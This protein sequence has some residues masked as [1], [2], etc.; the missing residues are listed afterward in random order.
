MKAIVGMLF[1]AFMLSFGSAKGQNNSNSILDNKLS[2]KTNNKTVSQILDLISAEEKVFFSFDSEIIDPEKTT[3]LSVQNKTIKEILDIILGNRFSYK[4]LGDQIIIMTK[5]EIP[6]I[7]SKIFAEKPKIFLLKGR[8]I[9]LYD[10]DVISYASILLKGNSIGT[11][12]NPDGEFE[13]KI[14]SSAYNDTI[15]VSCLGYKPNNIPVFKCLENEIS[16]FLKPVSVQLKEIKVTVINPDEIINKIIDKIVYNYPMDD[17]LMTSFYREVLKQDNKYIDVSEAI[18]EIKK[19]NY[20]NTYSEDKVRFIK[21]RKSINVQPFKYVDFKIQGGPYYITKLD[22]IKTI[23]SFLDREYMGYYKYSL[24][25][26][27]AIDNRDTYAIKF[28]P[29]ERVDY[30]CYQGVLYVDMSTLALVKAEF[31][32]SRSGLR[33]AQASLIKKKPK[34][35]YVRPISADYFVS[36]RLIGDKWRLSNAQASID[37]RV[38]SKKDKINSIFKSVS[39]LLITEI[40]P[41]DNAN[42]RRTE[43]FNPKD[44]FSEKILAYDKNYW[45]DYNIIKPSGELMKAMETYFQENDSLFNQKLNQP[46]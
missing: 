16:V 5:D 35:F 20:N 23:D 28:K 39:D 4:A 10:K 8:V 33:F 13:L 12:T 3:D 11:I 44:I 19:S 26:I 29:K 42:F 38:K 32:L 45:E 17:E 36:Y 25:E 7:D 1:A 43:I 2:I 46:L 18:M 30:P 34:D 14:P 40:K 21:G 31:S 22:V 24:E 37:F 15:I 6:E 27:L 9:D 41:N